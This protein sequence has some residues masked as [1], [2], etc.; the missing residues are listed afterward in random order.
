[1][2]EAALPVNAVY[3]ENSPRIPSGLESVQGRVSFTTDR[4]MSGS[5]RTRLI[6]LLKTE[7]YFESCERTVSGPWL[8]L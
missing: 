8:R 3:S 7:G 6:R 5:S 4:E 2:R 1:M